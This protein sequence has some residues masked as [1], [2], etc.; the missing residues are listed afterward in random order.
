MAGV[1]GLASS[2]PQADEWSPEDGDNEWWPDPDRPLDSYTDSELRFLPP[3]RM[4]QRMDPGISDRDTLATLRSMIA[5]YLSPDE[6]EPQ[7]PSLR[8]I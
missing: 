2:M 1:G 4:V 6:S 8:L 3:Y 5:G 7:Q